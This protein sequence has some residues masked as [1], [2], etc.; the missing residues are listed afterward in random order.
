M[1]I[2]LSAGQPGKALVGPEET[3]GPELYRDQLRLSVR[4]TLHC[5]ELPGKGAEL[6]P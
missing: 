4:R 2:F 1:T 5:Q 6:S 3:P